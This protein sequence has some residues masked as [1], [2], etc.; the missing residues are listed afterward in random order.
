MRTRTK[1]GAAG[2]V[3][4]GLCGLLASLMCSALGWPVALPLAALAAA[5]FGGGLARLAE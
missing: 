4:A 3:F 2:S 1:G 5:E